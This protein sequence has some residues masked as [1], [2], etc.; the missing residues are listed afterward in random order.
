MAPTQTSTVAHT[1]TQTS[2]FLSELVMGT[3]GDIL[4]HLGIDLT[5]LYR[6]W[7]QDQEA[8]KAWIEEGSLAMV[9]LECHRPDGTVKPVFEFPITYEPGG[10]ANKAFVESRASLAR[11]RAKLDSVPVGTSYALFVSYNGPHS[12]Q[13]GWGPG[14]RSST[15]GLSALTFGTLGS[16][17][18][19][20]VGLRYL[21]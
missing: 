5:R 8:I 1:R 14:N 4:A 11:Y 2:T 10:S 19:A 9:I 3:I 13:T 17:P 12:E 6:D 16:G 21:R 20:G 18:H 15:A 7:G